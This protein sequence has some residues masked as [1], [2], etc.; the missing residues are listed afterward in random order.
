MRGVD[1]RRSCRGEG[2]Q[3]GK[4]RGGRQGNGLRSNISEQRISK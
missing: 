2:R 3:E 1:K 4:G